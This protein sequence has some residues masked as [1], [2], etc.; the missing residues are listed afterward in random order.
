MTHLFG[1]HISCLINLNI[2]SATFGIG[3][4]IAPP[5]Y[6]CLYAHFLAI[7]CETSA[8]VVIAWTTANHCGRMQENRRNGREES[9]IVETTEPYIPLRKNKNCEIVFLVS[10]TNY[11]YSVFSYI[12]FRSKQ[13]SSIMFLMYKN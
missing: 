5:G 4:A 10:H 9:D 2:D 1:L 12:S 6:A 3:G 11:C 7:I 13:F 8:G